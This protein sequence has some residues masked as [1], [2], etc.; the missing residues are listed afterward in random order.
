LSFFHSQTP[1]GR[2]VAQ[3]AEARHPA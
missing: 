3:E 1:E 2:V